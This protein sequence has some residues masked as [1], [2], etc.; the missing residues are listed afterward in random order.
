VLI[1]DASG[2]KVYE[3][4]VGDGEKAI[5]INISQHADGLYFLTVLSRGQVLY[6][7]KLVKL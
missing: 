2:K 5:L 1:F 4:K 6:K 7:Q 3:E